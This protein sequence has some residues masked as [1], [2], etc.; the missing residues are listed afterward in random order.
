MPFRCACPASAPRVLPAT[1]VHWRCRRSTASRALPTREQIPWWRLSKLARCRRW[2]CTR[3]PTDCRRLRSVAPWSA[4]RRGARH[5]AQQSSCDLGNAHLIA[6]SRGS[7][8]R[9][10][11]RVRLRYPRLPMPANVPRLLSWS[12][13]LRRPF[14]LQRQRLARLWPWTPFIAERWDRDPTSRRC[15]ARAGCTGRPVP[16]P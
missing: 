10:R 3:S 1:Q 15:H 8:P 9:R 4:A 13:S 11:W 5:V 6:D 14:C 7:R 12:N 16:A 2:W